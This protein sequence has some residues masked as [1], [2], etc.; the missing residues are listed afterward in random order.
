MNENTA[1]KKLVSMFFFNME[2]KM[3]NCR[4]YFLLGLKEKENS[5][6]L[7]EQTYKK[8]KTEK[9]KHKLGWIGLYPRY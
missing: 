9:K 3:T 4:F 2:K 6:Y 5:L 8:G 7:F 1:K